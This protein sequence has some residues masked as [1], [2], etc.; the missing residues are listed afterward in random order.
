MESG[1]FK[2][3]SVN[4]QLLLEIGCTPMESDREGYDHMVVTEKVLINLHQRIVN[5]ERKSG[6]NNN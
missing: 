6:I 5:L 1:Y 2:V 4:W 3:H